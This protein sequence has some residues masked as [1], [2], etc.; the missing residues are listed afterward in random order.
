MVYIFSYEPHF[1]LCV[2]QNGYRYCCF[3]PLSEVKRRCWKK[4]LGQQD[5]PSR[6]VENKTQPTCSYQVQSDTEIDD[7]EEEEEE[8]KTEGGP[9]SQSE[10]GIVEKY[11]TDFFTR[12]WCVFDFNTSK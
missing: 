4:L 9:N 12:L 1:L 3:Q 6:F 2:I 10:V 5:S 7:N 11:D 8:G